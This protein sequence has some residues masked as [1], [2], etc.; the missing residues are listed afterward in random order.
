MK[1]EQ[2]WVEMRKSIALTREIVAQ[3][4]FDGL[5]TDELSPGTQAND[6]ASIDQFIRDTALTAYHPAATCRMGNDARAVVDPQCR[7]QGIDGLRVADAS[8]MPSIVSGNLN[9]PT[10]MIGEKASDMILGRTLAADAGAKFF[11][12]TNWQSSQR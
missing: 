10:M 5:R 2:D 11:Q 3:R 7:V 8:I 1:L 12:P 9:V 4:A 6:R